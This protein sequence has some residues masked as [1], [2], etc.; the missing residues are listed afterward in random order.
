MRPALVTEERRCESPSS[1]AGVVARHRDKG[2]GGAGRGPLRGTGRRAGGGPGRRA[3][4][5]EGG[6]GSRSARLRIAAPQT[7]RPA[8]RA[9][10]EPRP[11]RRDA[12]S[13][14]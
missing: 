10:Q 13:W 4:G 2:P 11:W 12:A 14:R 7:L 5:A 9:A 1:W 6:G 3:R 8:P